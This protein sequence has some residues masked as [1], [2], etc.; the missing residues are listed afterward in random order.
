[1]S[2]HQSLVWLSGPLTPP[3][4]EAPSSHPHW[5]VIKWYASR[6]L[7]LEAAFRVSHRPPFETRELA[8]GRSSHLP[9]SCSQKVIK[10]R[11][12]LTSVCLQIHLLPMYQQVAEGPRLRGYDLFPSADKGRPPRAGL[13]F[14]ALAAKV[15]PRCALV[16]CGFIFIFYFF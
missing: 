2:G 11:L 16:T 3:S 8:L 5:V 6:S 14:R 4:P 7:L 9:T 1:M 12:E 15:P 10:L 13:G